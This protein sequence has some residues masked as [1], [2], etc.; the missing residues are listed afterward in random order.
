MFVLTSGSQSGQLLL[1]TGDVSI[2]FDLLL[3]DT[4]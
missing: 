1:K 4:A 3:T 2:E